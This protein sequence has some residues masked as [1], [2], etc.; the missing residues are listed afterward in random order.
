MSKDVIG[1]FLTS[2]RNGLMVGKSFVVCPHSKLKEDVAHIL[3]E[4]G[5]IRNFT[6]EGDSIKKS[7][8]VFLKYV[9]NESVIHEIVRVSTP[10][11][12]CY[13]A[14][15]NLQPV[16]GGLGISILSTN[17]GVITNKQAKDLSVGGEIL[18]TVW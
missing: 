7:I 4:E 11:R 14:A 17:K 18:C 2:I 5:F 16:I 10:G 1:D 8:K 6:V 15:N 3:Q 13:T 12:R 9:D